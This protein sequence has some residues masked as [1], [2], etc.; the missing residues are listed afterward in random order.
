MCRE[1]VAGTLSL[2]QRKE[3]D[4]TGDIGRDQIIMS[5]LCYD[6]LLKLYPVCSCSLNGI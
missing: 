1:E 6:E 5:L 3:R 4:E 2:K